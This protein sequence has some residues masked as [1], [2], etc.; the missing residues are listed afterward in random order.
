MTIFGTG[1]KAT[2]IYIMW[3]GQQDVFLEKTP[4]KNACA[5]VAQNMSLTPPEENDP[6][7]IRNRKLVIFCLD[8]VVWPFCKGH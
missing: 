1:P 5:E 6:S 4:P 2:P 8:F 3:P 7:V